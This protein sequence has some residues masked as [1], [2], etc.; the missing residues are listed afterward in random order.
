MQET[1]SFGNYSSS[2]RLWWS[3][4]SKNGA[5]GSSVSLLPTC[6]FI[7]KGNILDF[8]ALF[9]IAFEPNGNTYM[10]KALRGR[11][12]HPRPLYFQ[13]L[14]LKRT[15]TCYSCAHIQH[16]GTLWCNTPPKPPDFFDILLTF[17][18]SSLFLAAFPRC[19]GKWN[20]WICFYSV[21]FCILFEERQTKGR[22]GKDANTF[23]KPL[24]AKMDQRL[25][26]SLRA[27]SEVRRV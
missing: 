11:H 21:Q 7:P 8:A 12:I 20:S 23:Q 25:A 17:W 14:L 19:A 10:C 26:A 2:I 1:L 13:F 15:V 18:T 4:R 9:F 3:P 22:M 16:I 27:H 5:K 6:Y 24:Q